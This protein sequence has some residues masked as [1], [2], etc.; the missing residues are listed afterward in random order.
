MW[1]TFNTGRPHAKD[2][3]TGER[4]AAVEGFVIESGFNLDASVVFANRERI[5]VQPGAIQGRAAPI[6]GQDAAIFA[7]LTATGMRRSE[8]LN[9]RWGYV[10]GNRILLPTS[11]N[12]EPKEVHLNPFARRILASIPQ[13][14]AEDLLFHRV[15]LEAVSMGFHHVCRRCAIR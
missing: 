9:C 5:C 15:T 7:L 2:T 10:D 6:T 3:G 11:Q 4:E 13:G 8:L 12:N 1:R 14:E